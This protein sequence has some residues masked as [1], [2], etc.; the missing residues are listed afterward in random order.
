MKIH[1][2]LEH[3]KLENIFNDLP[4]GMIVLDG[5]GIV[6]AHN[7]S[8]QRIVLGKVL[9]IIDKAI[10]P[11]IEKNGD[12]HIEKQLQDSHEYSLRTHNKQLLVL[13]IKKHQ[14]NSEQKAVFI[15]TVGGQENISKLGTELKRQISK[16]DEMEDKLEQESELSEM[17]SRFL[18]IASHE[19]RTPLAGILSSLNLINRYKDAELTAWFRINNHQ[20]IENHL[21]KI[22]ESV[23]NLTTLINKFLA[24]GNI[25]KGEIPVKYAPF[26]LEEALMN[27]KNQIQEIG[28]PGQKINYQHKGSTSQVSLD[29]HLLKNIIN[30]LLSNALKFS[31]EHSEI[32]MI[33]E[34]DEKE[35]K[36][37]IKDD[38]IGIP[39]KEQNKIFRRFYR[40]HNALTF[41]EGTGLGLN[42]VKKYV[43][44]MQGHISFESEENHGTTFYIT[45]PKT[46]TT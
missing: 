14:F 31:Y 13:K 8:F 5:D 45:F 30:N 25:A 32:Q 3:I 33:S 4:I 41:E 34:I 17:K 46:Q 42:I 28:K 35:I 43:E 40:A 6:L 9:N 15:G 19:F 7:T 22:H 1:L 39:Q 18:S 37:M 44:L 21:D 36:L 2:S 16:V 27:Q 38:G 12:G 10:W 26:N 11:F 20:K 24:L 29:Q 23:R